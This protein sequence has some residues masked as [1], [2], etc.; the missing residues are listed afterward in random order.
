[1]SQY[2]VG[3]V[4][5]VN[6]SNSVVGTG[7]LFLSNVTIGS[8]FSINGS[9]VPY[10]VAGIPDNTHLTLNAPYGGTTQSGLSYE[11]TTSFTP[12]NKIPYPEAGDVDTATILKE[13]ML[14]IDQFP[15]P[16]TVTTADLQDGCVT[17]PKI[18]DKAVTFAKMQDIPT[19]TILG[20]QT[21]GTGSPEALTAAQARTVID[22]D[23]S[24]TA[25]A[26][27]LALG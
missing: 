7:T 24:G 8:V 27:A 19:T 2:R 25:V 22:V 1:M 5:V 3:S 15:L 17:T 9:G 11:V 26:M 6:G 10:V 14:I 13:A 20:R 18:A 12:N 23:Q 16:G 21:A 4:A